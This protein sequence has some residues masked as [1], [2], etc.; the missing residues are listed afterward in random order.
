MISDRISYISSFL[1][2]VP[3]G[4]NLESLEKLLLFEGFFSPLVVCPKE[5]REQTA[6]RNAL[7]HINVLMLLAKVSR[8]RF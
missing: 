6:I 8:Q 7:A 4:E 1:P 3:S 2:H 5:H